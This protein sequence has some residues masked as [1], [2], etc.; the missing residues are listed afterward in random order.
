MVIEKRNVDGQLS[1]D[2]NRHVEGY[3]LV[4]NSESRGLNGFVEQISP[5]AL[6]GVLPNQRV[7]C[8]L[9]HNESRGI[10]AKYDN[11]KGTLKLEVDKRGLKYSFDAPKTPLGDE[12]LEGIKRGDITTS[13][14]AFKCKDDSWEKRSDG[15][16]LRTINKFDSIFDV[17]PVYFA[18]Y[19]STSVDLR[20]LNELKA[21]EKEELNAYYKNLEEKIK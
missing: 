18:A 4:F 5:N 19:D 2:E 17:S 13:S 9:D 7:L 14:F 20:G 1:S 21:K 3:A 10:L 11:G 12:L 8:L 6:D 16:Y 15:T